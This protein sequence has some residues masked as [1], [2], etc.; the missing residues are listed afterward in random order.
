MNNIFLLCKRSE[1][2]YSGT[3][4]VGFMK[5]KTGKI[6]AA[7]VTIFRLWLFQNVMYFC[8]CDLLACGVFALSLCTP[9]FCHYITMVLK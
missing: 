7:L 1:V 3:V 8:P 2:S 4:G 5:T 6:V 9:W